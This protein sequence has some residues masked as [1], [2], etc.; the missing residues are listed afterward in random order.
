MK[1]MINLMI[2]FASLISNEAYSDAFYQQVQYKCDENSNFVQ[3]E[4][5]HAY[6]EKGE[7]L[8]KGKG[9][10]TWDPWELVSGDDRYITSTKKIK[11]ACKL[12]DGV[13]EI[14]IGP[15]VCNRDTQGKDGASLAGWATIFKSG[16]KLAHEEF[17]L[18]SSYGY[19]DGKYVMLK[20]LR[21]T[22][23]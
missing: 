3:I 9:K 21:P 23:N 4:W 19:V 7:A 15:T 18:C 6:N 14:E 2:A 12:S 20:V 17:G 11:R 16:Q 8:K 1:I 10:N 13:Y 22:E 5:L